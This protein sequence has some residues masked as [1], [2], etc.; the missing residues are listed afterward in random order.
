MI[1]LSLKTNFK[2]IDC[3][4]RVLLFRKFHCKDDFILLISVKPLLVQILIMGFKSSETEFGM[5]RFYFFEKFK[6][7]IY[8]KI[9]FLTPGYVLTLRII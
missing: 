3:T 8:T 5:G 7:I 2:N 6:A 4:A 1:F 9:S